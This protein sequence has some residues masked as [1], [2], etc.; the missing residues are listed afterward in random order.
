MNIKA[1]CNVL[2]HLPKSLYFNLHYL[3]FRDA[4]KLPI[5]FLSPVKLVEMGGKVII[6]G[7]IHTGMVLYGGR[8]NCHYEHTA[9]GSI[10]ANRGG[11]CVFS[12]HNSF[13]KGIS[14]EIGRFG[15]LEFGE[16]VYFGPVVRLSCFD[17]VII[18]ANSRIAWE[19][20]ILDTDFH[21][22]I[23][24]ETNQRSPLTKPI[25]IGKNNW[26]GTRCM[27]MKGT[28]TPDFC[29]ASARSML[30][31]KYDIPSY[32]LIGGTP[33]KFIKEHLFR[34]LTS[35]ILYNHYIVNADDFGMS[36]EVNAAIDKCMKEDIISSTTLLANGDAFDEAVQ[37]AKDGGYIDRIGLHFNLTE[38][39]PLTDEIKKCDRF[40][41]NGV[42]SYKRNQAPR[43]TFQEKI[44]IQKEVKAQISKIKLSGIPLTHFDS[45]EHVH[46]EYGIYAAIRD[47]LREEGIE[48]IRLTTNCLKT[49]LGKSV[50]KNWFNKKL[51]RD[52]FR[53]S[54]YFMSF[55][56]NVVLREDQKVIELMIHPKMENEKLI[57]HVTGKPIEYRMLA[58]VHYKMLQ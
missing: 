23:N 21:S 16:N 14:I 29:I 9:N 24:T 49:S 32:S 48:T 2:V 31:K 13:C 7:K 10:W 51:S 45:H 35:N 57:D 55:F 50:Y 28:Q 39:S 54:D 27:V 47:V 30:N 34:D 53:T 1:V 22:T 4:I 5:L 37:F 6:K 8:G 56:D 12:E 36:S 18:G 26:I 3:P 43:L 38:G 42:F 20:I 11:V 46:T 33:A 40:C 17:K 52:G 15:H 19:N 44:A 58:K 41:T 25:V